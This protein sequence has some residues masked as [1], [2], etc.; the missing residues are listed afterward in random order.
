MYRPTTTIIEL[1]RFTR[2][3][4]SSMRLVHNQI[5]VQWSTMHGLQSTQAGATT[6]EHRISTS[7]SPTFPSDDTQLSLSCSDRSQI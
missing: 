2:T 4:K 1:R 3:H 6:L 5:L 7:L